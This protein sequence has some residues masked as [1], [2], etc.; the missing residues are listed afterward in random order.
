LGV[1]VLHDVQ[2]HI[3]PEFVPGYYRI[4]V[5]IEGSLTP[6]GALWHHYAPEKFDDFE[7]VE[8]T[9]VDDER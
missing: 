3:K 6:R 2:V 8:V 9:P 5:P 4:K 7:R 1:D